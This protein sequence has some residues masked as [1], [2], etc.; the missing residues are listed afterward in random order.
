MNQSNA[1][2]VRMLH[3]PKNRSWP[4]C[5]SSSRWKVRFQPDGDMKGKRP[6]STS[7]SASADQSR[8]QSNYLLPG[9][10][11]VPPVPPRKALKN[12]EPDGSS[13]ITSPF[14]L[15]LALYASRLR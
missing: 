12:S 14:L 7:T 8:S 1:S 6:S 11:G 9:A 2:P 13:T 4:S 15:K 5:S 10:A 3:S